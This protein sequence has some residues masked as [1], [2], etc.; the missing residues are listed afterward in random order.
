MAVSLT[1]HGDIVPK[2]VM[3][4]VA[5]IK[6]KREIQFVDWAPTG[7]KCG[8]QYRPLAVPPA[9]GFVQSP[10]SVCLL[11]N[12]TALAAPLAE[13]YGR[14]AALRASLWR[15][16]EDGMEESDFDEAS[17]ELAALL[18]DF[19]EVAAETLEEGGDEEDAE[20]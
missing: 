18:A 1:F 2:D 14:T 3:A 5:S 6:T 11:A 8:I 9:G 15:F 20:F 7:F 13:A 17:A 12:S 16:T 4:A 10:R 19:E